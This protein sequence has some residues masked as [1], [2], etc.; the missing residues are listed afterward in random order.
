MSRRAGR[1]QSLYVKFRIGPEGENLYTEVTCDACKAELEPV[2]GGV[3]QD[4]VWSAVQANDVLHARFEGGYGEFLDI[5]EELDA[6]GRP[7][8]EVLLCKTCAKKLIGENPWLL[9]ILEP[10]IGAAIGH[11]CFGEWVWESQATCTRDVDQHGWRTVWCVYGPDRRRE[12]AVRS[13]ARDAEAVAS[14]IE[15][16][17]VAEALISHTSVWRGRVVKPEISERGSLFDEDE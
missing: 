17:V 11:R 12:I 10:F 1:A 13:T 16:A 2:F 5:T 15:G 8:G 7:A 9:S 3:D 6:H 14:S 4:G